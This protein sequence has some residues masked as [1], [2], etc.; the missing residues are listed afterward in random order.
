MIIVFH[1]L[2]GARSIATRVIEKYFII[3]RM[4]R[5]EIFWLCRA[6]VVMDHVEC[7]VFQLKTCF[8]MI[9]HSCHPNGLRRICYLSITITFLFIIIAFIGWNWF[10]WQPKKHFLTYNVRTFQLNKNICGSKLIENIIHRLR[11]STT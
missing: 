7:S 4:K 3:I 8:S 6:T 11:W 5:W 10:R 1:V 2:C 9:T